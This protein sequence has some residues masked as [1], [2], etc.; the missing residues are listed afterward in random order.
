M[1]WGGVFLC[2]DGVGYCEVR[3]GEIG[4]SLMV[5]CLCVGLK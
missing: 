2:E 4:V 5:G 3:D 1:N